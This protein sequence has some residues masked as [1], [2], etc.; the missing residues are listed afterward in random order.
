[1]TD[2]TESLRNPSRFTDV[3]QN[4]ED[5]ADEI[6]KLTAE[7]DAYAAAADSMAAAHKVER[8]ALHSAARLALDALEESFD[9]VSNA[10]MEAIDIWGDFPPRQHRINALKEQSDK[11]SASIT[12]LKAVL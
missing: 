6:D 7:R 3:F 9:T 2:L 11:H 1:M 10:Y 12:A 8:D 4:M 5:A